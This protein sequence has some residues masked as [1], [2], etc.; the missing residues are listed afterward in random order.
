MC[1]SLYYV[2][3]AAI[4]VSCIIIWP[5]PCF[6]FSST[7]SGVYSYSSYATMRMI[8]YFI[9]SVVARVFSFIGSFT[10]GNVVVLGGLICLTYNI[11]FDVSLWR[12]Y[13]GAVILFKMAGKYL[14]ICNF[15]SLIH[16]NRDVGAGFAIASIKFSAAFV[17]GYLLGTSGILLCP[18]VKL[19]YICNTFCSSFLDIG[20]MTSLV[21][22]GRSQIPS[23]YLM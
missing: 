22:Y 2:Y 8:F 5:F 13:C 18:K 16:A 15:L 19:L 17:A 14:V 10:Q 6:G 3:A 21:L 9:F 20:C 7:L 4:L 12:F 23:L 11:V 1:S